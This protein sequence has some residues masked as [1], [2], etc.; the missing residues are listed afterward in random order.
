MQ[1]GSNIE[2]FP[3]VRL[4]SVAL[5]AILIQLLLFPVQLNAAAFTLDSVQQDIVAANPAIPQ[6]ERRQL[7]Q[8]FQNDEQVMLFDVREQDEFAVSH[9]KNAIRLDPGTW[10][11]R[12]A[13]RWANRLRG[14]TV[15]FYCS[16]GVRSTKMAAY[17]APYLKQ[18]G[19]AAVYNL[20]QGI[21]GWANAGKPMINDKGPTSFV[22]PFDDH[23]GQLLNSRDLWRKSPVTD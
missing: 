15:V 21:F 17:L 10:K 16:V 3:S 9:L 4:R 2:N 22:H 20:Q 8:L 11:S 19:A 14:K 18:Q 12:F 1:Q 7:Q 23:W 6:L 5:S 13:A